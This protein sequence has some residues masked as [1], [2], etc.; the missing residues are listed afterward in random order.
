MATYQIPTDPQYEFVDVMD[1]VTGEV[2]TY[3]QTNPLRA[4][5]LAYLQMAQHDFNTWNYGQMW[6]SGNMVSISSGGVQHLTGF[7]DSALTV[8]VERFSAFKD[9]RRIAK[10]AVW[11]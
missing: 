2:H 4:C 7:R 5:A 6:V 10:G 8:A 9:G 11:S 1:M 3:S